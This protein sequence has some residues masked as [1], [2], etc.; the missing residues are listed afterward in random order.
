MSYVVRVVPGTSGRH[1]IV[2]REG[3]GPVRCGWDTLQ[4]LKNEYL[5]ED[6]CAV[7]VFPP[8][9]EVVDE[10][11]WRHLWEVPSAPSLLRRS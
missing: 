11:N 3:G 4:R 2:A 8:Q 1:M 6:A 5:G 9:S 10:V 7:E